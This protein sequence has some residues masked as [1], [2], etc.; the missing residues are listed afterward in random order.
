MIDLAGLGG[1]AYRLHERLRARRLAREN[2]AVFDGPAADG[3]PLPPA[4]LMVLVG[5]DTNPAA[6]LN[7]GGAV[8]VAMRTLLHGTGAELSGCRSILDFGCGCG[9][10][11][12]HFRSAE[13]T[14]LRGTDYNQQLIE[15]CRKNLSFASF[16]VNRLEPPLDYAT[17]T[18]DLV[19]AFSIFTHFSA[20]LQSAW[21]AELA[22]VLAPG[23]HLFLTVHG[24]SFRDALTADER[25]QFDAGELVVRHARMAGSNM[26]TAFH[27]IACLDRLAAPYLERV[28]HAPALLGQDAVLLRRTHVAS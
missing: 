11:M 20:A 23:G 17:G 13:T 5:G 1:V 21:L 22:R 14:A 8:I 18:F 7:G 27:P 25:S 12:R 10:V 15:W 26:C 9:R 19:Y 4:Q 6:F 24:A 16:D 28:A 3:L 2:A